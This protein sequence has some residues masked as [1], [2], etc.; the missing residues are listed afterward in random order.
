MSSILQIYLLRTCMYVC[1]TSP[2]RHRR[3]RGEGEELEERAKKNGILYVTGTSSDK[4]ISQRNEV[5]YILHF[6]GEDVREV[7]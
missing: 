3:S 7:E 5:I 2:P 4:N 6:F 1:R